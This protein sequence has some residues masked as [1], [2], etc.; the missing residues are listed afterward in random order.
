MFIVLKPTATEEQIEALAKKIEGFG[1]GAHFIYGKLRT[2]IAVTGADAISYREHF[3]SMAGVEHIAPIMKSFKLASRELKAEDTLIT[4]AGKEF[5]G[6]KVQVIAGPCSVE[7]KDMLL[8]TAMEVKRAGAN[9]L[10]GGAYKPRTSP[11]SFQGL[12]EEGL[13]LLAAAR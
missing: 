5:G 12:G 6:H 7:G 2:V 11:Y 4:V 9:F 1:L 10:R 13:L 8:K 3:T